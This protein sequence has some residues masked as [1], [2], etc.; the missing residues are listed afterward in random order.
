MIGK[1]QL[2]CVI[3]AVVAVAVLCLWVGLKPGGGRDGEQVGNGEV[4]VVQNGVITRER[5][6]A[7]A[8]DAI[9]GYEHYDKSGKIEV[10][11]KEGTYCVTFPHGIPDK[12]GR[13]APDYAMQVVIDANSGEVVKA[14]IG[15]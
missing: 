14:L 15:R 9:K 11:L 2:T 5:A 8:H 1:T 3:I 6:L 13:F 7:I 10:E 12:P 4:E